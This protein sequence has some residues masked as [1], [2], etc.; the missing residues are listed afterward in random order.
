MRVDHFMYGVPELDA[1]MDVI[2]SCLGVRPIH[3]GA[4]V[5]LGTRN[6]LLSLGNCYLEVIAPDPNQAPAGTMG[7]KLAS[8][9]RGGL[10]TWAIEADLDQ[11]G[12]VLSGSG[13]ECLGPNI[14]RRA[15]PDG[16]E[17]V[18]QLL[19]AKTRLQGMPFFIDWMDCPNPM[20][21]APLGGELASFQ[22]TSPDAVS[23]ENLFSSLGLQINL[24]EGELEQRLVITSE[25]GELELCSTA[26]TLSLF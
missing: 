16:A 25:Q 13:I 3:G 26:E 18:W 5:G 24:A 12:Q 21:T 10:A 2:E 20:D 15:Q 8:L 19:F 9:S 17:L 11:V 4:H 7:E 6:A 1:A 23:L 14:T 22:V